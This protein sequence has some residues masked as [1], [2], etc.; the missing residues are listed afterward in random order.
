MEKRFSKE[1]G[2]KKKNEGE[3]GVVLGLN[4]FLK[5]VCVISN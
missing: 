4:F 3:E 1:G 5:C 2:G